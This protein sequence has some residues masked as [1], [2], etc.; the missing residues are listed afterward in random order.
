MSKLIRTYT[1]SH[2]LK[3]LTR[4]LI[5]KEMIKESQSSNWETRNLSAAQLEYAANDVLNLLMIYDRLKAM[6]KDR[7][8][9]PTGISVAQLNERSQQALPTLVELVLN[10]YGDRDQGWETSV[11]SH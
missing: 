11:F 7:G 8:K 6:I 4:E 1:E 9:L 2:S 5:G 10:G 3:E